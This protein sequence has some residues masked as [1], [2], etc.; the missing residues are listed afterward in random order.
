MRSG[1]PASRVDEEARKPIRVAVVEDD[2]GTLANLREVIQSDPA[3]E[4]V[5]GY[6]T[7][8]QAVA[9]LPAASPRVVVVDVNLPD[10]TGVECVASLA[11]RMPDTEFVML[12]VFKDGDAL[13]AAL[14]AGAHGYLIKPV[15]AAD[16][17]LAIHDVSAGGSPLSSVIARRMVRFFERSGKGHQAGELQAKLGD[18]MKQPA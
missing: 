5:G 14:A 13:F 9:G 4:W 18:L 10:G 8:A 15:R 11:P 17:L 16:L 1:E 3:C 7:A 12:T 6:Q 2:R